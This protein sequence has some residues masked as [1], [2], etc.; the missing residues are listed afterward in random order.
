MF[1]NIRLYISRKEGE[2]SLA[3]VDESA[4]SLKEYIKKEQRKI[5]YKSK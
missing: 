4:Q 5:A 1:Q 3:C 2:D